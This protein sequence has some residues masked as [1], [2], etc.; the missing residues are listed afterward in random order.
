LREYSYKLQVIPPTSL[1]DDSEFDPNRI[2]E[3]L[4]VIPKEVTTFPNDLL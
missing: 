3:N 1:L 2:Y 4:I